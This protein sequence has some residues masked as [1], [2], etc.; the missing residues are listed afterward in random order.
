MRYSCIAIA[1]TIFAGCSR[2]FAY[3]ESIIRSELKS[4][5]PQINSGKDYAEVRDRAK[6]VAF[7][8]PDFCREKSVAPN[9][10]SSQLDLIRSNCGVAMGLAERLMTKSGYSV[11]SWEVLARKGSAAS[12]LDI[13]KELGVDVLFAVNS[14]EAVSV[15]KSIEV[16]R[17]FFKSDA[18]GSKGAEWQM[19][20]SFQDAIREKLLPYEEAF[21]HG[22]TGGAA[23]DVTAIDVRTG[24]TVW[25]YQAS[26]YDAGSSNSVMNA[27]VTLRS[28]GR[29]EIFK[30][31]GQAA[32]AFAPK[33]VANLSSSHTEVR[34][35]VASNDFQQATLEVA[36]SEFIKAFRSGNSVESGIAK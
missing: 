8:A 14:I 17:R 6:T 9:Q 34:Q 10:S 32:G 19:P 30:I 26:F 13:G 22:Q 11:V 3:T 27:V 15:G 18:A 7:I 36:I 2:H 31:N 23:I 20:S 35:R 33:A 5:Q 28:G 24:R 12:H 25:Y 1:L 4:S 21:L 16:E 29:W